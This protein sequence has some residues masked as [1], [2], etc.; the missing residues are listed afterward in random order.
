MKR[1]LCAPLLLALIVA[2]CGRG[3]GDVATATVT[4]EPIAQTVTASG[5]LAAQ[6]TVLVGS[7]DSGTIQSLYVDYNSQVHKGQVLARLDPSLFVAQL[8]QA[9]ATLSQLAAQ[10]SAAAASVSS[11]LSTSSAAQKTAQSQEAQI[12]AADENVRKAQSALG[13]SL[14]TLHRDRA[15]LAQGY[16]A[17][18]VVDND[19]TNAAA[20]REALVAA[21]TDSR[22]SRLTSSAGA[23]QAGSSAAAAVG[24][25]ASEHASDAAVRA[26]I[27][28]VRQAE[29][30]LE[31]ATI[32][33]PV[34]GTVRWTDRRRG[35][36]GA[37]A[38]YDCEG[39]DENGARHRGRRAGRGRGPRGT[40]G[41]IFGV[42]VSGADVH[43]DYR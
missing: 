34:D 19:V 6:D 32:T 11:S 17:Q 39:S 21:Q 26:A 23:Y 41:F 22:T 24:A 9:L 10:R 20:A 27:A 13:L 15:L 33:S 31:H 38:L 5:T 12:V 3:S 7:Q 2:A 25:A 16:V 35:A 1:V 18:N 29:I 8:D 4:R 14:L 40:T 28:A 42:G 30:N 43:F 36:S 37:D